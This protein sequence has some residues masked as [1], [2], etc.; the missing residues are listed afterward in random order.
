M[1]N[2]DLAAM[3]AD[4]NRVIR[5]YRLRQWRATYICRVAVFLIAVIVFPFFIAASVL[6]RNRLMSIMGAVA[7]IPIATQMTV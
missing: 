6:R 5:D 1:S 3:H 7:I 2:Y 4:S